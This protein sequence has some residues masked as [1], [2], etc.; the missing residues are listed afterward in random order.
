MIRNIRLLC[1]ATCLALL[2]AALG[3]PAAFAAKPISIGDLLELE[4]GYDTLIGHFYRAT[5]PQTLADG[6]YT[7]IVAYL[8]GR[9]IADPDVPRIRASK[10]DA[11]P[12]IERAV[13]AVLLR[14]GDRIA[15]R[16]LIYAALSGEIA[17]VHDPY[18]VFFTPTRYRDFNRFLG[19]P[20]P[21]ATPAPTVVAKLLSGETGYVR[22][23]IFGTTTA[24]ELRAAIEQLNAQGAR[25]YVLDLRGNSG[26]YR[27]AAL[28]VTSLFVPGGPVLTVLGQHGRRTVFRA[29]GSPISRKPLA[30][31]VNGDTASASEI[32]AGAIQD[33]RLGTI[34]GERTYGKGLVQSVFPL[35]DGAAIKVT[36]GRYY[37][38]RGRDI[39]AVGITP[40][41]AVSE[42]A[43][44]QLGDPNDD[45]QLARALEV[46]AAPA[47][48]AADQL[49]R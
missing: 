8:A 43:G 6:A 17:A 45:P 15:T 44:A 7:G 48:D 36:T 39:D 41:V 2:L 37:T 31:L 29:D 11:I 42:P 21:N 33:D 12:G 40:N 25:A 32:V 46:L 23:T 34:V 5:T 35:P 13:A 30:V 20:A 16:D 9:R 19:R 10:Q 14:Y 47:G 1:A 49:A 22:L 27:D 24:A 4:V 26:G 3:M 18:T 38:A 28:G